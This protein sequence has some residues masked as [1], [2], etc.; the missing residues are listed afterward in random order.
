MDFHVHCDYSIDA[1]GT[2]VDYASRALAKGLT[3]I[4]F[5][6]HC[7]LDPQRRHHDGRVRLRGKIVDV[8]SGWLES[9]IEDIDQVARAFSDRGLEILSGL[10]IGYVP[11]IEK[12][13]DS[14]VSPYRFDFILGGVHTLEGYDIVSSREAGDYFKTKTPTELCKEYYAYLKGAASCGLFDCIAHIDIYKRCG[15]DFYGDELSSAHQG[16][17]E[18]VLDRI[19]GSGLALE[20][21]SGGLRKGLAWP[22]PS[23]DILQAASDAGISQVTLGSDCHNPEEIGAGLDRCVGLAQRAGLDSIAVFEGRCR[24]EIPLGNLHG[25]ST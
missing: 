23:P 21:N 5:T 3:K 22:Y 18:P 7:D 20:L 10:E 15:L 24:R 14:V 16:L 13:I 8:T 17:V 9:Y 2:M 6:T 1:T 25:Q 11:G 12:M 4:C 19:A